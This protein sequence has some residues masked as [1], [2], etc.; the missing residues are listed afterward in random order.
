MNDAVEN[1]QPNEKKW[2]IENLLAQQRY[3]PTMTNS[4]KAC[5]VT[6]DRFHGRLAI[7][8]VCT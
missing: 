3:C 4:I 7:E 6:I 1:P 8:F 5:G 2:K